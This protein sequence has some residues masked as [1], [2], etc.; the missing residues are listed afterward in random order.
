MSSSLGIGK[1][2]YPYGNEARAEIIKN[3][4]AGK[5]RVRYLD[6]SIATLGWRKFMLFQRGY[7]V[8]I[9]VEHLHDRPAGDTR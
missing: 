3:E 5:C 1:I 2:V 8:W 6:P 7:Q 4:T 9:A